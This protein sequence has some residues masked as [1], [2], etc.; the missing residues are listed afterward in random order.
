VV[1]GQGSMPDCMRELS[2]CNLT[3]A[4]VKAAQSKP[5]LGICVGMQMLFEHSEEGDVAGL[6]LLPGKV[7]RFCAAELQEAAGTTLK[8]PHM[9]WN[10][11]RQVAAHPLWSGVADDAHFYFVHGYYVEPAQPDIIAAAVD[12]GVVFTCAVARAN[13]FATQFHPEKSA[14]VGLGLLANFARWTP[15]HY[16]Q[17]AGC[18]HVADTRD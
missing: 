7:R 13:I 4:V 9:G 3:A 14:A 1:P 17:D 12:Y 6:G 15:D 11:V 8:I 2:R 10:Q 18:S 16:L 5:F